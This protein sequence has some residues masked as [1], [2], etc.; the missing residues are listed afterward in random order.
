MRLGIDE[1]FVKICE[2]FVFRIYPQFEER[3]R[4]LGFHTPIIL[5]TDARKNAYILHRERFLS[6][7][8]LRAP[9]HIAPHIAIK[10]RMKLKLDTRCAGRHISSFFKQYSRLI[11][12]FAVCFVIGLAIGIAVAVRLEE[13][14]KQNVIEELKLGEYSSASTFFNYVFLGLIGAA[15]AYLSVFKRGF[16]VLSAL[17]LGFCGYRFGMLAVGC[18]N[19]SL[20]T[21]IIC[22]IFIY[23]P[24]YVALLL[25]SCATVAFA[26]KYWLAKNAALTC[27]SS[28]TDL[29]IKTGILFALYAIV[30]LVF[31]VIVPWLIRLIFL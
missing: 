19:V 18:V 14:V 31:C 11:L 16:A 15:I 2:R 25:L 10:C 29:L 6:T 12:G 20:A 8:A 17:W 9:C 4:Y 28:L 5:L 3:S 30:A 26:S 7:R 1:Q 24:P 21:G 22:C 27:R 23:L 13:F